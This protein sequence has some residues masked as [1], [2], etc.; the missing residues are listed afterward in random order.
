MHV[1]NRRLAEMMELISN[2]L[3]GDARRTLISAR[4]KYG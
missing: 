3:T 1:I 4:L 2:Q